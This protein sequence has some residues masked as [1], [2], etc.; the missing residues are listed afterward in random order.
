MYSLLRPSAK[1][2]K[3]SHEVDIETLTKELVPEI[4][5]GTK[6]PIEEV[7]TP[8]YRSELWQPRRQEGFELVQ[9]LELSGFNPPPPQAEFAGDLFYLHLKTL[10]NGD[11]H[12]T[13]SPLGFYQ[14]QS[15]INSYNPSIANGKTPST[16]LLDLLAAI[17]DRFSQAVERNLKFAETSLL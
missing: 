2:Q 17:S 14:N 1:D 12:I 16:N 10:E 4:L 3:F 15:K 5:K 7:I 9:Y 6:C 13:A 8:N 11:C